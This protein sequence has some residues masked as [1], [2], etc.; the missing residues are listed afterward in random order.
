MRIRIL[1]TQNIQIRIRN[2]A[3]DLKNLMN[4]SIKRKK[5]SCVFLESKCVHVYPTAHEAGGENQ[6]ASG[7]SQVFLC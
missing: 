3:C 7:Q 6:L 4:C 5:V 2:T 1:E